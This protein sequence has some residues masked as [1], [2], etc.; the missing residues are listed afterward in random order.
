MDSIRYLFELEDVYVPAPV[1][2]DVLYWDAA[3]S[4]WK[5]K[6]VAAGGGII[7]R[8][9]RFSSDDTYVY[10][11][12]SL[13]KCEPINERWHVG[14]WLSAEQK[15]GG[16][17]RFVNIYI[18]NG[19][20]ISTA[21]LKLTARSSDTKPNVKSKVHGE[22]NATPAT[23]TNYA[24]YDARVRTDAVIP[25]DDIPSWTVNELYQSPAIKDIIQEI[26]NLEGWESGN[27]LVLFW[28]DHDDLT[29][30]V[31]NTVRRAKSWDKKQSVP[32]MLYIEWTI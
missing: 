22:K 24:D 20:I 1:D 15:C 6:A 16:G 3:A 5:A 18:P 26:I 31:S 2:G 4:L 13:W 19:A 8:V 17:G 25:W 7:E 28:D 11:S 23:F 27:N 12:G 9:V 14:Y 21:Y 10:W 29:P 30:H 32:P